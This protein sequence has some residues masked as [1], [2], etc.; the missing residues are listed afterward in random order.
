MIPLRTW[1]Y[2]LLTTYI[3]HY[4]KHDSDVRLYEKYLNPRSL[5]CLVTCQIYENDVFV[6][7]LG[8]KID[9]LRIMKVLREKK[10]CT[11]G[12]TE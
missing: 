12:E 2:H 1:F 5:F 7:P 9:L 4:N 10:H 6:K 3:L 8:I 11:D